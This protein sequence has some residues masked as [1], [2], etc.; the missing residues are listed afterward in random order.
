MEMVNT[1]LFNV[2][3]AK[4][5][6][7]FCE[8]ISVNLLITYR[9]LRNTGKTRLVFKQFIHQNKGVKFIT[10]FLKSSLN[11]FLPPVPIRQSK[12]AQKPE[13]KIREDGNC[14]KN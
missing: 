9:Y 8:Q 13:R 14:L 2:Y 11:N 1:T 6:R 10:L 4:Y 3:S 5:F 12:T 7:G